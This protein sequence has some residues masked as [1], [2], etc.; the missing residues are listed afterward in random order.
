MFTQSANAAGQ[1]HADLVLLDARPASQIGVRT[2]LPEPELEKAAAPLL[3][4][5]HCFPQ[6]GETL[7]A[8]KIGPDRLRVGQVIDGVAPVLIAAATWAVIEEY[9]ALLTQPVHTLVMGHSGNERRKALDLANLLRE[10]DSDRLLDVPGVF[11]RDTESERSPV[12]G[13]A[14]P[15]EEFPPGCGLACAASLKESLI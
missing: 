14:C 4:A 12:D 11:G 5:L 3:G 1:H 10:Y 2:R 15:A 8:L 9:E 6:E 7:V 13:G